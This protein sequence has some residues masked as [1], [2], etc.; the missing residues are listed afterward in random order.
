MATLEAGVTAPDFTLT[1]MNG[2]RLSLADSLKKGPVLAAFFKVSCP[3]C[4]YTFPYLERI[5]QAYAKSPVTV[6]GVSQNDKK[7]TADFERE[8]GI[9][10]PLLLDDGRNYPASNA[11]GLTNV[12]SIFLISPGGKID[13]SIVG[14]SKRDIEDLNTRVA[15]AAGRPPAQIFKP[16]EDVAEFKAG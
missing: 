8:Y 4:Q 10:F 2:E 14:W 9:T 7:Q 16:G 11:Y 6:V 15:K 5:F 12:P 13:V 1:G 3:T